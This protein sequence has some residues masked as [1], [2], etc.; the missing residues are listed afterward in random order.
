MK[1]LEDKVVLITGASSELVSRLQKNVLNM[2]QK[3]PLHIFLLLTER[4][5]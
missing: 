4:K 5:L 1:L 3:L 2:E